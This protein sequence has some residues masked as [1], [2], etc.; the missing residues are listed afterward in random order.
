MQPIDIDKIYYCR[1]EIEQDIDDV[2][3]EL[4]HIQLQLQTYYFTL[5]R[6]ESHEDFDR[7]KAK[8]TYSLN[9]KAREIR[10]LERALRKFDLENPPL[11]KQEATTINILPEPSEKLGFFDRFSFKAK[12]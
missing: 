12:V 1:D 5:E 6:Y 9:E 4:E 10:R 2:E 11:Q 7:W 8:A 3:S